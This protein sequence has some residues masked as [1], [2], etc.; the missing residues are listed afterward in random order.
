MAGDGRAAAWQESCRRDF[1]MCDGIST[2][3]G[4]GK[5][6][7]SPNLLIPQGKGYVN[8]LA[9]SLLVDQPPNHTPPKGNSMTTYYYMDGEEVSE[10]RALRIARE[11]TLKH[12]LELADTETAWRARSRD[13]AAREWI[14]N[15]TESLLEIVTEDD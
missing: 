2:H 5:N 11:F 15:V 9:H 10:K 6:R 1:V 3:D 8:T 7:A 14:N 12:G 4:L 13:E